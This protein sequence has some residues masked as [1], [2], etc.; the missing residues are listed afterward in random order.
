V[1]QGIEADAPKP[2]CSI[3]A[4][5][6]GHEAVRGFMKSNGDDYWDCPDCYQIN[7]VSAHDFDSKVTR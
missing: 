7:D 1:L 2:P 4:K 6:V 3:I 5:K